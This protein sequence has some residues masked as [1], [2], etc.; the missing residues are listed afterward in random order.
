MKTPIKNP[1]IIISGPAGVG[2]TTIAKA[3]QNDYPNLA[4]SVTYTTR[5]PRPAAPEDKKIYYITIP[6]FENMIARGDFLEWAKV[7]GQ[8]YGTH[9]NKT[10]A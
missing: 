9:K 6:D 8:Y 2:K 7:H 10:L 3:L 4:T 1:I 5:Q